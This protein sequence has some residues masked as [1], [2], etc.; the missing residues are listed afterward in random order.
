[1]QAEFHDAMQR[2]GSYLPG[3]TLYIKDNKLHA[4]KP[5]PYLERIFSWLPC[6]RTQEEQ[7]PEPEVTKALVRLF[8]DCAG[9]TEKDAPGIAFSRKYLLSL[10]SNDPEVLETIAKIERFSRFAVPIGILPVEILEKIEQEV[11]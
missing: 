4:Q 11:S 3:D 6:V 9:V 5:V 2:L 7:A 1:M 8:K 10:Q